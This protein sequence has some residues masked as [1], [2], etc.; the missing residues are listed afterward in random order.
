MRFV[1]FTRFRF[2]K[3]CYRQRGCCNIPL[4]YLNTFN[5]LGGVSHYTVCGGETVAWQRYALSKCFSSHTVVPK[6]L[7]IFFRNTSKK[8]ELNIMLSA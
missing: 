8:Y 4:A 1:V 3:L 7:D 6:N 5:V 2:S